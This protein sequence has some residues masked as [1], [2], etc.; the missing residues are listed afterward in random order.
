MC[1]LT[2]VCKCGLKFCAEV[3]QINWECHTV[4]SHNKPEYIPFMSLLHL[5]S[6]QQE[7]IH[8]HPFLNL[9]RDVLSGGGITFTAV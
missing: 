5:H 3:I 9:R 4:S 1:S 7:Y 2:I 6:L 8:M